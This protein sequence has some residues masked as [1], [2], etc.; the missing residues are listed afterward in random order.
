MNTMNDN[1]NFEVIII[2]GS[3]AGLSAGMA[4]GRAS[5][6]TLIID[7]GKPC[8][9]QTPHSHNFLTQDGKT[10]EEISTLAK[11]QVEKY[12]TTTF[13][14]GLATKG[15]KTA[16]GFEI[17]TEN[18]S[19]FNAKKLIFA[20]GIKDIMPKIN[21][22]SECW[23]IS[24]IHCPYCHGY[25]Y[26][27]DKTG[28]LANGDIAFELGKLISNWTKDLT[29]FSN[30]ISTLTAEQTEKLA[31]HNIK[32]NETEIDY[33]K[34][35]KG[36]LDSIVFKN[37]TSQNLKAIYSRPSFEQH[38]DIPQQLNCEMTEQQYI[39]IDS[40]QK[41]SIYGVYACGDNTSMLRSVSYAVAMGGIAGVMVNKELIEENF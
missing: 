1:K 13:F 25:E 33:F 27:H 10:P 19:T 26:S 18:G 8:N 20:T 14:N 34:H 22:F 12:K 28:L 3:Y 4:L 36:Y 37:G 21:G 5:R 7:S 9:I 11:Q 32:I 15:R 41:T 31:K 39:K 38:C 6:N 40:F 30:G 2:G 16:T 23:G 17:Q 35:H 29:I 24:V